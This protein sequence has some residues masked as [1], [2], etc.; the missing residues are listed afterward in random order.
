GA[1][2]TGTAGP[3]GPTGVTGPSGSGGSTCA[4]ANYLVKADGA[5]NNICTVAP[6]YED[7]SGHVGVGTT[8]PVTELDVHGTAGTTLKIVDGLQANGYVLTS[9]AN[10][11]ADWSAP[12]SIL[13]YGNNAQGIRM[14]TVNGTSSTSWVDVPGMSITMTT[15]HNTFFIFASLTA[16]LAVPST[17]MAQYG[18]AIVSMRLLV[19]GTTWA[20]AAATITDYDNTE[21]VV[22]SGTVA[23]AGIPVAAGTGLHT[24]KLQWEAT[25]LDP[26]MGSPWW[27]EINPTFTDVGDHCILTVFD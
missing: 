12:G 10:G 22:T 7:G 21:G 2:G 1:T 15:V 9:D 26:S 11:V 27:I 8:T 24:I 4:N 3:T 14:T 23:F 17:H 6:V 5:G 20:Q 13:V 19:D 18:M 16:R 25:N